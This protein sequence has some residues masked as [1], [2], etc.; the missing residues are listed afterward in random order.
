M[1]VIIDACFSGASRG[2]GV[3][4]EENLIAAKGIKL[5]VTKPWTAYKNFIVVNSSSGEETSLGNDQTETGLFTYYFAAGL[6]GEADKDKNG[7]ITLGEL[8]EYVDQNM[9]PH[10]RRISGTQTPE[11]YGDPNKVLVKY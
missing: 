8:K 9:I 2:S 3:F 11:F 6:R 1:T 10:A 7:E 4:K 5:K